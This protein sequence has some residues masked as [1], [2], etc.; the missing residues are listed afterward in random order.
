V[1]NAS[2]IRP[3]WDVIVIGAGPAGMAT[4][5]V[6]AKSGLAT[7]VLDENDGVGGQVWRAISTTPLLTR[8]I[9][10]D[11]Y[12]KGKAIAEA[13]AASSATYLPRASVWS[14]TRE[15]EVALSIGGVSRVLSARRVV[16][17]TGAMERPFPIPGWTLP[18]VMSVGAGQ[19]VLKASGLVPTGRVV[20]AGTGPLLWLYAAQLLGAGGKIQ[21]IL[22]TTDPSRRRQALRHAP[23]FALSPY[24]AKGL[25]LLARVRRRVRIIGA[26]TELA[27]EGGDRIEDVR[28]RCNSEG[29]VERMPA[30]LLLLHQGVVPNVNLAMAAGIEH[31]WCDRQLCFVPVVDENGAT[32]VDGVSIAGDGAGIAGAEAAVERGRI[33]GHDIAAALSGD[34]AREADMTA[35]RRVLCRYERGRAFLDTLYQP[36]VQFRVPQGDTIACRCEEVSARQIVD[37]VAIGCIGPNQMKSFL[38]CGMGP[39]QGRLCSLTVTETIAAARGVS[40]VEIGHYRL[41]PPVKPITLGELAALPKSEAGVRAVV[42]E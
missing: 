33:V 13:F 17:A 20:L 15:R 3:V 7:L 25:S 31:R 23:A 1:S 36:A 27:A 9:L 30:D 42:R 41:R 34:R 12:W 5:T 37:A 14:L 11:D 22:D 24:L 35:A 8:P 32:S 38:R 10:G 29:R 40:P 26:V 16:I 6:T 4:A 21:A 39:C 19:T 18:G 2:D 28:Y